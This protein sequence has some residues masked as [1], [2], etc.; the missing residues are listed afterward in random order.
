MHWYT[1]RELVK[2]I[3]LALGLGGEK[4]QAPLSIAVIGG[5]TASTVLALFFVSTFLKM[6]FNSAKISLKRQRSSK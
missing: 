5:L 4:S 3:P 2:L 1:F 6:K